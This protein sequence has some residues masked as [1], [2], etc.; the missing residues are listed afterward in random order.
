MLQGPNGKSYFVAE[1]MAIGFRKGIIRKITHESVL[2][3]E[4]VLNVLG[5]EENVDS[6]L[7]LPDEGK[8]I[9][10]INAPAHERAAAPTGAPSSNPAPGGSAPASTGNMFVVDGTQPSTNSPGLGNVVV[11]P[12]TPVQPQGNDQSNM[13]PAPQPVAPA[14]S[15]P[16]AA[17]AP[18]PMGG[19]MLD[20]TGKVISPTGK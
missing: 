7:R 11:N 3:R 16:S 9:G 19:S 17:S 12:Q 1:G 20:A 14:T 8:N 4:Q 15:M 10:E 13:Q 2:V 18:V 5:Q 6:E